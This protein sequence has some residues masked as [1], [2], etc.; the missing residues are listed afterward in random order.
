MKT[1][2]VKRIRAFGFSFAV[3]IG[4]L[5]FLQLSPCES[6]LS[7][8]RETP[9]VR[10]VSRVGPAVV[11]IS[12]EQEVRKQMSPFSGFPMDPFFDSF[13]KDFF[14]PGVE[15][16]YKRTSLG[17]GVIID[18]KRG[19]ILTNAHVIDK[20]GTI[21]AIL[22]DER[23]FKARIVGAD[24]DTDLAVLKIESKDPLPA[25][26]MGNSDDIMIGETVIAIGNPFGF[27]HTVTTGVVSALNRSLRS[28]DRV[29]LG[30]I[31]TDASINPGNSGGPLLNINGD[32]IGINTAIYAKAQG[33]G[34][35]IPINKAKRIV[36]DLIRFGEVV[37][38]WIGIVIQ[39]IDP[40]IAKY[41]NTPDQKG[42]L[43]KDVEP[44]SPAAKA[45]IQSGDIIISIG[46][47]KI[48]SQED[49]EASE[50]N[51]GVGETVSVRIRRNGKEKLLSLTAES[52]PSEMA[53]QLTQRLLGIT[54]EN[55]NKKNKAVLGISAEH[56]VVIM[57]IERRSYLARIGARPGDV[58]RQI[59]EIN[60]R[61]IDE[62]KKAVI[63]YRLKKSVVILLQREDQGYYITVRL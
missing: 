38:S 17:S 61:N 47:Q 54:V 20:T 12:S 48:T 33:I 43:V 19:F 41:L 29:F 50:K 7:I 1:K 27:S 21:T 24:P 40:G 59:N 45:S 26:N 13:F 18:G 56:G 63:Q 37:Q 62:F 58:I 28:E 57:E 34:F 5:L 2:S 10:A 25:I 55:L 52:F 6:A 30:F 4:A 53:M 36:A 3:A 15:R 42:V 14:D 9:V 46:N 60:V 31:Q 11:N 32:L 44:K 22:Q 35:A 51:I 16:R 39:E 23:E 49:Y 8:E